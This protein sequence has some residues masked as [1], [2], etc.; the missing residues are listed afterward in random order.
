[1]PADDLQVRPWKRKPPP[2]THTHTLNAVRDEAAERRVGG[3]WS[4]GSLISGT[5]YW[6]LPRSLSP[7]PLPLPPSPRPRKFRV[8][9]WTWLR[10]CSSFINFFLWRERIDF[11]RVQPPVAGEQRESLQTLPRLLPTPSKPPT[12]Y[13]FS[14]MLA[15]SL[16]LSL[17]L[18][19]FRINK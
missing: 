18:S 2:H 5:P 16:S 11:P 17:S 8:A 4:S 19:P 7:R 13:P 10:L 3:A 1:M 9:N 14:H 15:P 6:L 12:I